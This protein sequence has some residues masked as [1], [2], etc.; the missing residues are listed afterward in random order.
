MS[1][2][3]E[4][5]KDRREAQSW[6]S[7]DDEPFKHVEKLLVY[8]VEIKFDAELVDSVGSNQWQE[9]GFAFKGQELVFN[10]R[11]EKVHVWWGKEEDWWGTVDAFVQSE[12]W[13]KILGAA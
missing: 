5:L 9:Y 7:M 3:E 10:V 8:L 4:L 13:R 12:H 6:N 11:H 2:I 1:N